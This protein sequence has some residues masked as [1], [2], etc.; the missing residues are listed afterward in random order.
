[1]L[2]RCCV[3]SEI[4]VQYEVYMKIKSRIVR[5]CVKIHEKKHLEY[6]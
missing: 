3:G 2:T 5:H 4:Y 6:R 1:M